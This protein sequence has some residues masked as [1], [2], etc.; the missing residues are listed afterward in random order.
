MH[1]ALDPNTY[2]AYKTATYQQVRTGFALKK[3]VIYMTPT[4]TTCLRLWSLEW[5]AL[6]WKSA[7]GPKAGSLLLR[8]RSGVPKRQNKEQWFKGATGTQG[9]V[10]CGSTKRGVQHLK[11]SLSVAISTW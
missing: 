5:E 9:Q 2:I 1:F 8:T 3:K 10:S 6:D 7:G 11:K 4:A